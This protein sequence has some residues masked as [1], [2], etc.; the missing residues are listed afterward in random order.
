MACSLGVTW[1]HTTY[2]NFPVKSDYPSDIEKKANV[3]DTAAIFMLRY[4]LWFERLTSFLELILWWMW[5]GKFIAKLYIGGL[6]EGTVSVL[7]IGA[8]FCSYDA[9]LLTEFSS[10]C[11]IHESSA[12]H[13]HNV[14]SLTPAKNIVQWTNQNLSLS[15]KRFEENRSVDVSREWFFVR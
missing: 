1:G 2:T 10:D 3:K 13:F 12:S 5:D 11:C 7:T 14:L 9:A 6:D 15:M 4:Y 8:I